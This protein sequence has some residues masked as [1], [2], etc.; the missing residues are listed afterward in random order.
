MDV[1]GKFSTRTIDCIRAVGKGQEEENVAGM[2]RYAYLYSVPWFRSN[3]SC[4]VMCLSNECN[5]SPRAQAVPS[6][7]S[8]LPGGESVLGK[9]LGVKGTAK[10]I[11]Y[12]GLICTIPKGAI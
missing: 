10:A 4:E 6:K 11:L 12:L 8:A 5:H 3:P 9:L 7:D 2:A 1:A